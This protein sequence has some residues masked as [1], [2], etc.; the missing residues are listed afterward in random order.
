[1]ASPAQ[2]IRHKFLN[3]FFHAILSGSYVF[4]LHS[5]LH[6]FA[7]YIPLIVSIILFQ[8]LY[9]TVYGYSRVH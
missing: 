7:P 2:I 6:G 3:T 4:L 1:M 5:A 9:L 8:I